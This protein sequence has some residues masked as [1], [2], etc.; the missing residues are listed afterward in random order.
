MPEITYREKL[1]QK[2]LEAIRQMLLMLPR[3]CRRFYP[4]PVEHNQHADS[5]RLYH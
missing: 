3:S 2:R 5:A 1:D 4:Q